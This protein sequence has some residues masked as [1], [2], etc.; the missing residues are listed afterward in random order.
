[1]FSKLNAS[2]KKSKLNTISS[3]KKRVNH[4][5]RVIPA[6]EINANRSTAYTYLV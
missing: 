2:R 1:M 4:I 5:F 6:E 3:S